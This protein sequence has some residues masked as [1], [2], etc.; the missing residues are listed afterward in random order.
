M[1]Y[2][3]HNASS[4][5]RPEAKAAI[6]RAMEI[7]GNASSV[8][9]PGRAA[10]AAIETAREV[11]AKLANARA[12]DVIFT[13]GG[14]EANAMVE[15]GA[16]YG[17]LEA[18]ARLTRIFV[19]A[20]EHSS[21]IRT[22]QAIAERVAGV[23]LQEIPVTA[24]GVVD[25]EALR[26]M[27]REGK[28]RTLVCV[29]AANNETG[30]I[31]PLDVIARHVH[32][33]GGLLLIDAVQAAGKVPL[34]SDWDYLTLSA[35]KLGGLQ[36]VGAAI[37]K[38]GAPF[39][40]MMLGGG[41]ERG[42]RAGTENVV[43]IASFGA[44]AGAKLDVATFKALRD[45]FETELLRRWPDAAV[46]GAKAPRIANTSNFAI[47]RAPSGTAMMSLD[48]DGVCVSSGSACSSGKVKAS[49]VLKA[50]GVPEDLAVCAM[51]VSFGWSSEESDVDALIGS[52]ENFVARARPQAAA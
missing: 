7:G 35:H 41:H 18:E 11:V 10:R 43:G 8:H 36:G 14:A 44:V 23:R 17:A 40:P 13:S 32:E 42:R 39:A 37:V 2:L 45:R 31:Q 9:G 24:D 15:W 29:M 47:P 34:T 3:D 25:T 21:V 30:V 38:E 26:V 12:E 20:V 22:A 46:F 33:A 51:R 16:V 4:P 19:S 52:L 28:G 5:L 6:A 1:I 50:M 49:H 48:L 27:L